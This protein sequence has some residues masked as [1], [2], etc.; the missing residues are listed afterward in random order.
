MADILQAADSMEEAEAM[1]TEDRLEF[2]TAEQKG[3]LW[4][5]DM[6]VRKER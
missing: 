5:W 2:L 3:R 1:S 4:Y 6:F